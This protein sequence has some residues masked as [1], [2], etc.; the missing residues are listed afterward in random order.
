MPLKR[1]IGAG[2]KSSKRNR[3]D[4]RKDGYKQRKTIRSYFD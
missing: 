2:R 3:S 4:I 1:R